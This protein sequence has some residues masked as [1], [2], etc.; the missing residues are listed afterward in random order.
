MVREEGFGQNGGMLTVATIGQCLQRALRAAALGW[1]LTVPAF[2]LGDGGRRVAPPPAVGCTRDHLTLHIGVV[3]AYRRELE[4]TT[5]RIRTDSDTTE[6]VRVVH[7]QGQDPSAHFLI[8]GAAFTAADWGR[9][10]KSPGKIKPA[11][12]AAAWVCDDGAPPLI[13][14]QPPRQP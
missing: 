5:L 14:W 7:P 10:E 6:T 4:R 1:L 13:D 3:I 9:I 8:E 12:R 2:A 11:M